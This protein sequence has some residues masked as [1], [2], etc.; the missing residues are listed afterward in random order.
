MADEGTGVQNPALRQLW[1]LVPPAVREWPHLTV[2]SLCVFFAL[3]TF[4]LYWYLGPQETAFVHH[5]NQAD[6]ILHG[7]LDINPDTARNF[8]TLEKAIYNGKYYLQW[9]PGPAIMILPGVA[10]WG[11]DLNQTLVSVVLA[12]LTA[13][14]VFLVVRSLVRRVSAQVWL[15]ILFLFGTIF[16]WLAS[17]GGVWFLSQTSAVMFI[18]AAL[19][20]TL[21][22]KNIFLTGLFLGAAYLCRQS[23]ILAYPFFLIMFMDDLLASDWRQQPLLRKVQWEPLLS[24][25]S[26]TA[27]FLVFSFIWN[28]ARFENPLESGYSHGEQVH[29]EHLQWL[30]NH[31]TFHPSYIQRHPPIVFEALPVFSKDGSYVWPSWA[32]QAIWATTPA[33]FSALFVGIKDRRIVAGGAAGLA[34]MAFILISRKAA[35]VWLGFD[36]WAGQDFNWGW[37]LLPPLHMWPLYIM[38]ALAIITGVRTRDR[39]VIACWAAIV[40]IALTNF[41]F[42]ATGWAQFGY[43]YAMDFYP[44]LFLLVV[45]ATGDGLRWNHKALI[46]ASVLINL[47]GIL[48]IYQFDP[49]HTWDWTWVSF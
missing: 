28:Y 47:W 35:G 8:N 20:T 31:G 4:G 13:P 32:G 27:I 40:P 16:W 17:N 2:V 1:E 43:R 39:F 24:M 19:F 11:L 42:A 9:P 33:F 6:A 29:Q 3:L 38:I 30:Y 48:W 12:A 34:L 36:W 5:V 10:I 18:F 22:R 44:F 14:L 25:A 37:R 46:G 26:G 15:T 21:V 7:H 49:H 23:V 45:R 41:S